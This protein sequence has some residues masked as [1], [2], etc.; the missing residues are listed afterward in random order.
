MEILRPYRFT[1]QKKIMAKNLIIVCNNTPTYD[2][3]KTHFDQDSEFSPDVH[4]DQDREFFFEVNSQT[5]ADNLERELE[6]EITF[7]YVGHQWQNSISYHF[8]TRDI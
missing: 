5:D 6:D 2:R 1:I 3:F 8:E 7:D 4:F